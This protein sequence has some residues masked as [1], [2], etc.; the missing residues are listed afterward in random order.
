MDTEDSKWCYP[1]LLKSWTAPASLSLVLILIAK[2]NLIGVDK[3]ND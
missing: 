2:I 1:A 3:K